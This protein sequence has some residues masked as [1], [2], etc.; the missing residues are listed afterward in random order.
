MEPVMNRKIFKFA[1]CNFASRPVR[2]AVAMKIAFIIV[3]ANVSLAG[4][5]VLWSKGQETGVATSVATVAPATIAQSEPA[6]DVCRQVEVEVD[7][8]YG[9]RGHVSR[10]VCRKAL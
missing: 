10:W 4:A 1:S 3:A 8:G 6:K 7:E 2:V 9:V 5:K